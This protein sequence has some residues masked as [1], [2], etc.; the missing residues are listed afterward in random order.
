MASPYQRYFPDHFH[1]DVSV[2]ELSLCGT[3]KKQAGPDVPAC[4]TACSVLS[5]AVHCSEGVPTGLAGLARR[6]CGHLPKQ[7]AQCRLG[8]AAGSGLQ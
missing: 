5:A 6:G 3:R 4:G 7:E 2:Q 1:C 8:T